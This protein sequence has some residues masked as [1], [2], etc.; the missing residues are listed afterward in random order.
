MGETFFDGMRQIE[1]AALS[2]GEKFL[3]IVLLRFGGN[4]GEAWPSHETLSR[5]LSASQRAVRN[6]QRSLIR[7]GVLSVQSGGGRGASNRYRVNLSKLP[8]N[9]EPRSAF[10][11]VGL[12][13][14][15]EPRSAFEGAIEDANPEPRSAHPGTTFLPPRNHVPTKGKRKETERKG[16]GA[17]T[18][19]IKPS[20]EEVAAFFIELGAADCAAKFFDHFEANG[21][22]TRSGPLKDWHAAA[23]NW[24]RREPEFRGPRGAVAGPRGSA[25]AEKVFDRFAAALEEFGKVRMAKVREQFSESE[26]PRVWKAVCVAGGPD[27]VAD[28]PEAVRGRFVEGYDNHGKAGAK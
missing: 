26:W 24:V 6:W 21:W 17:R 8:G 5:S 18:K 27:A 3:L 4:S 15:P 20:A 1:A 25:A 7:A 11:E 9:P 28:R 19:F 22:R 23:R 12:I 2:S 13:A 14:N 16:K 10:T